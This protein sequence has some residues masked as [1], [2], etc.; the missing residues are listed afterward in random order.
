ME[1]EYTILASSSGNQEQLKNKSVQ[2]PWKT[3]QSDVEK[4]II[5]QLTTRFKK[6]TKINVCNFNCQAVKIEIADGSMEWVEATVVTFQTHLQAL[7]NENCSKI[8][9]LE[10]DIP[11]EKVSFLRLS[12]TQSG[13]RKER[14]CG[15]SFVGVQGEKAEDESLENQV[16]TKIDGIKSVDLVK[17]VTPKKPIRG[18]RLDPPLELPSVP[19]TGSK[20]KFQDSKHSSENPFPDSQTVKTSSSSLKRKHS[21]RPV[22]TTEQRQKLSVQKP[23][24]NKILAGVRLAISGF[25]GKDREK[26]KKL[27][28]KMGGK[29]DFDVGMSTT[30]SV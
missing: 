27:T 28:A 19:L 29:I 6:L 15:L 30:V 20:M 1:I 26:I 13:V 5:L 18:F 17:E 25:V 11:S 10:F 2:A 23:P 8:E 12:C 7:Q 4:Y 24:E 21:D 9:F 3:S 14:A 16:L 22:G